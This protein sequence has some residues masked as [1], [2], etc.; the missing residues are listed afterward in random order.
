MSVRLLGLDLKALDLLS[1]AEVF[2]YRL[3][4]ENF[5]LIKLS[6]GNTFL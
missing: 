4:L 3:I 6:S 1:L 2:Q 5:K